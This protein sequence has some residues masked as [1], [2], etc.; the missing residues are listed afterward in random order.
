[1]HAGTVGAASAGMV[2]VPIDRRSGSIA[3]SAD[4][5]VLGISPI[6]PSRASANGSTSS[7]GPRCSHRAGRA[8]APHRR[9]APSQ[10]SRGERR[11]LH[12]AIEE[13]LELVST[14]DRDADVRSGVRRF[15]RR[16]RAVHKGAS[17]AVG[18]SLEPVW[19]DRG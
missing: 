18:R 2:L 17:R 19:E 7:V 10:P 5:G 15:R 1:M 8:G 12:A 16:P 6:A 13:P 3:S 4:G 11:L 9:G 14:G